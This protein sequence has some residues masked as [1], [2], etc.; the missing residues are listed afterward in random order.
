EQHRDDARQAADL[1]RDPQRTD[2]F[3]IGCDAAIPAQRQARRRKQQEIARAER[4]RHDH[5]HREDEI[6]EDGEDRHAEPE[7]PA[8][9]AHASRA[10]VSAPPHR[11]SRLN[12]WLYAVAMRVV[13]TSRTTPAALAC[14]QSSSWLASTMMVWAIMVSRGLPSSAGVT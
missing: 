10:H 9:H 2:P 1:Q 5:D 12:Q 11:R 8:C 13:T 14:G 7:A 3:R 6:K 4:D